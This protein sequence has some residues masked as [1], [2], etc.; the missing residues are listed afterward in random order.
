[1]KKMSLFLGFLLIE[2]TIHAQ[3]V[4]VAVA[5]NLSPVITELTDRYNKIHPDVHIRVTPGASGV[6]TQ[7]II[8]G[9]K[10]DFFMSADLKYP[11]YLHDAGYT[12]GDIS[13]YGYG[14]LVIWS[15]AVDVSGGIESLNNADIVRI[16]IAKPEVSP[17]GERTIQCLKYYKMY[18]KLKDN[19]VYA[20]NIA[21]AAQFA[22]TG[23]AE[24]AFLAY[25][26]LFDDSMKNKGTYYIPD[27]K[28]YSPIEQA[29][30]LLKTG[31]HYQEAEQ[32]MNFILSAS[33]KPIFE[34][35][36]ITTP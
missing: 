4:Q 10:Y 21:Q 23:N 33:C 12:V 34:K 26:L 16:A 28:S 13:I 20:G 14:K 6:L 27:K 15:N 11:G 35:Y 8:H 24:I 19:L 31:D 17:F 29:C 2:F 5:A 32:F 3:E 30:V 18:D 9:A 1:M 7:Q 25:S 36:G 22:Q